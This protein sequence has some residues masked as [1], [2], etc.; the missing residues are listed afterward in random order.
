M[1]YNPNMPYAESFYR[2]VLIGKLYDVEDFTF[3]LS[4]APNTVAEEIDGVPAAVVAACVAYFAGPV[5][6]SQFAKLTSIKLNLIGT[7]GRYV[8][9]ETIEHVLASPLP[10]NS[11]NNP[12][13]Q[14]ALC[15]ST[16][17]PNARGRAHAGRWYLPMPG[18]Q[19]G[20]D[21]RITTTQADAVLNASVT[22]VNALNVA[23]GDWQASVVS[24]IGAGASNVI[25]GLRVGRVYDTM[26]SRRGKFI[27]EYRVAA[28]A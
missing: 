4:F 9:N 10:G 12:A 24:N 14:V 8:N 22:F 11:S 25:T 2:L 7:D 1:R 13:P 3:S 27:E 16:S 28:V 19:L 20:G 15:V 18:M 23:M 17:T 26:R 21:G 5:N 6:I